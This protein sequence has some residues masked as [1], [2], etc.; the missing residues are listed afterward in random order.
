MNTYDFGVTTL[1]GVVESINESP[2]QGFEDVKAEFKAAS[3]AY[4]AADEAGYGC[5]VE[6]IEAHLDILVAAGAVFD[7]KE[8]V[9]ISQE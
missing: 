6:N 1:E 9:R 2:V 5:S 4:D 8:A 3:Y 7:Y